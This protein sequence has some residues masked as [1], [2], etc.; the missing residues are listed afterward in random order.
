MKEDY[1]PINSNFS[2][3]DGRRADNRIKYCHKCRKCWERIRKNGI[4]IFM[5]YEDFVIYGKEKSICYM[6]SENDKSALV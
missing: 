6:C 3:I 2:D 1:A 4:D 5:F